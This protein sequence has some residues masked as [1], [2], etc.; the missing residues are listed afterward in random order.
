MN[1]SCVPCKLNDIIHVLMCL[2]TQLFK[3]AII[4]VVSHNH[5]MFVLYSIIYSRIYLKP[6]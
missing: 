5:F 2:H 1:Y 6:F 3:L 4:H